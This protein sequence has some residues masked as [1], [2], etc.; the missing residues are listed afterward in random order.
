[1]SE[2]TT[3]PLISLDFIVALCTGWSACGGCCFNPFL[4]REIL[5]NMLTFPKSAL[6]FS[7]D[8]SGHVF[9]AITHWFLT[10]LTHL[11]IRILKKAAGTKL[12]TFLTCQTSCLGKQQAL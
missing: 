5:H 11:F 1:M 10:T 6:R 2:V 4:V 12:H 7:S 8:Q 3:G 9:V